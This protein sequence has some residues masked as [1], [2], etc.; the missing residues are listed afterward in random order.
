MRLKDVTPAP[1]EKIW[2]QC[3]APNGA[4]HFFAMTEDNMW[5]HMQPMP[6][7]YS[8]IIQDGP[9]HLFFDL[10][11][12]DVHAAWKRLEPLVNAFLELLEVRYHHVVLD[13][14]MGD[15]KSL[16]IITR[17]DKF[18]L[19]SPVQGKQFVRQLESIHDVDLGLDTTIYTRNRCFRM[20]GNTKFESPRVLRGAWTKE[21]WMQT[22][23]QPTTNL[24]TVL[25]MPKHVPRSLR[26]DYEL[27]ECVRDVLDHVGAVKRLRMPMS[28]TWTGQLTK[29][30]CKIVNREHHSNH[31]YYVFHMDRNEIC[32]KCHAC[33]G[34]WN[35]H[36]PDELMQACAAFLRTTVDE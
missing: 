16:H 22:L 2:S 3:V 25:W 9:C 23:V 20:L 7:Y 31:N 1:G 29:R 4:K 28:W 8:E 26:E 12:G 6:R 11:D 24:E 36:V 33:E 18:V 34:R 21:F 27:P 13:A 15:K 30:V 19:A 35:L 32:A 10:D 17:A 5:D 14:S